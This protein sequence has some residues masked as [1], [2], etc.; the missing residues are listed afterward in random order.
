M[1]K[2]NPK[3][4]KEYDRARRQRKHVENQARQKARRHELRDWLNELKSSMKCEKCEETHI[5]CLQFHHLGDKDV[6]VSVMVSN[7][8]GKER[9]LAEIAKCIVLC[10]NCHAKH[11]WNDL[12]QS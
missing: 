11:H 8:F 5:G 1:N 2:W 10:A 6:E 3:D 4:R 9:I 7:G 12:N